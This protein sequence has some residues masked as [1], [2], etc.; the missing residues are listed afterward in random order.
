MNMQKLAFKRFFVLL[1]SGTISFLSLAQNDYTV[2][3]VY[4]SITYKKLDRELAKGDQYK[5]KDVLIFKTDDSRAA[6]INPEKGRL[7]ITKSAN[8]ST[9]G[10]NFV[11]GLSN[12]STRGMNVTTLSDLENEFAGEYLLLNKVKVV[13]SKT[14]FPLS[15]ET[16]FYIKYK[17]NNEEINKKLGFNS[18]TLIIDKNELLTVDGKAINPGETGDMKIY[19]YKNKNSILICDFIT[20]F[21][22]KTDLQNEISLIIDSYKNKE[23][24]FVYDEIKAYIIEN[25][26]KPNDYDL[27]NW[28]KSAFRFPDF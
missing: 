19:Y 16:F 9:S 21:P 17:Y 2:L 11:P 25:Y 4:G 7:M 28:L 22:D 18:D 26:G 6:V 20:V 5:E 15:D 27:K 24:K 12:V 8:S 13:I 3:K 14:N 23:S 10:V 1:L